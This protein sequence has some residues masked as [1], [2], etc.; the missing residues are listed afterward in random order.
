MLYNAT[1]SVKLI[2]WQ[3][4]ATRINSQNNQLRKG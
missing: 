1:E 3:F 4:E 2:F